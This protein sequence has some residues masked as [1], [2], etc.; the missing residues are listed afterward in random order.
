MVQNTQEVV[1]KLHKEL[2]EFPLVIEATM[3]E[4]LLKIGKVIK[5]FWEKI[6]DLQ[7]RSIPEIPP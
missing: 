4:Q 2:L 5:G 7:L 3:E 6:H 1:H